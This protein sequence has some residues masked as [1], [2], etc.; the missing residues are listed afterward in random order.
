M[1]KFIV[2]EKIT[3]LVEQAAFTL[4]K[5]KLADSAPEKLPAEVIV[6]VPKDMDHGDLTTNIALRIV[7]LCKA[8]PMDLAQALSDKINSLL[9]ENQ[10]LYH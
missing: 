8:R 7:K 5:E 6:D 2:E 4:V 3:S 10:L 1:G 9:K